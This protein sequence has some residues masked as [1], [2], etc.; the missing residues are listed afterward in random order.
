MLEILFAL[1][2]IV[3][4]VSMCGMCAA[5]RIRN[6][7]VNAPTNQ[8]LRLRGQIGDTGVVEMEEQPN[9]SLLGIGTKID[10]RKNVFKRPRRAVALLIAIV[11]TGYQIIGMAIITAIVGF[12]SMMYIEHRAVALNAAIIGYLVMSCVA[13]YYARQLCKVYEIRRIK[14]TLF[15]TWILYPSVVFFILTIV[16]VILHSQDSTSALEWWV[17]LMMLL[18]W[19]L[20]SG[21][22]MLIG[23][24]IGSKVN[25]YKLPVKPDNNT[26]QPVPENAL[27]RGPI[28]HILR[29]IYAFAIFALSYVPLRY[30]YN[31]IWGQDFYHMYGLFWLCLITLFY[32]AGVI[33]FSFVYMQLIRLN[34]HW[35]WSSLLTA[36][37]SVLYVVIFSIYYLLVESDIQSTESIQIYIGY[38]IILIFS[39]FLALGAAG[40]G[41]SFFILRRVF[42]ETKGD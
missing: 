32:A 40:F 6:N 42:K 11:A 37:G 17:L 8:K 19:I 26:Q 4:F 31:S 23:A 39:L 21:I 36:G 29:L 38:A 16:N 15:L 34:W 20:V 28:V 14:T 22:L 9:A 30:I 41:T 2:L 10:M 24:A 27:Y 5:K 12:A 35:A 1:L 7:I 25:G 33:S 3:I 13:G 18:V